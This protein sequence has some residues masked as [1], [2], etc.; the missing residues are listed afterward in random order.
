MSFSEIMDNGES[1]NWYHCLYYPKLNNRKIGMNT[2]VEC[3]L[4]WLLTSRSAEVTSQYKLL[5][6][7]ALAYFFLSSSSFLLLLLTKWLEFTNE[8]NLG[9]KGT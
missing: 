6:L 2:E 3:E 7:H 4:N 8:S 1:Q 9:L 5:Q